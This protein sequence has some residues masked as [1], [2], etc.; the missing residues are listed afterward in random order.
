MDRRPRRIRVR[1]GVPADA[2]SERIGLHSADAAAQ[3]RLPVAQRLDAGQGGRSAASA[4]LR[5]DPRRRAHARLEH[6]RCPRRRSAGAEGYRG[7]LA[8]LPARRAGLPGAP[9]ADGRSAAECDARRP[10]EPH[11][12]QLRR[13]RSDRRAPMGPAEHRAFGGDRGRVTI[14]GESAGSWS[15]NTLLATP[16]STGLFHRA[17]GESG[18][19]FGRGAYLKM[20][21]GRRRLGRDDRRELR[22]GRRGGVDRRAA[23]GPGSR[24][25]SPCPG[26]RTQETIDGLLLPYEIRDVFRQKLQQK[27]PVL[28]GSNADEMTTLGGGREPARRRWRS[29]GSV[30]RRSTETW[31]RTSSR[32]T[33]SR[34]RPTSR[35]RSSRPGATRT[36]SWH[37]RTWA[38]HTVTAGQRAYLYLFSHVPPSPRASELAR[39]SRGGD[40]V[41]VQRA[42]RSASARGGLRLHR[43]RSPARR[44]DVELLGQLR[45]PRRPE[46]ARA[47]EVAR[48]RPEDASRTS[49][50]AIRFARAR[51]S[52]RRSST[53]RRRSRT[54]RGKQ[55]VTE[56]TE[57]TDFT[58]RNGDTRRLMVG[59]EGPRDFAA[60]CEVVPP[61]APLSV[62]ETRHATDVGALTLSLCCAAAAGTGGTARRSNRRQLA[63]H[64]QAGHRRRERLHHHAGEEGRHLLAARRPALVASA[65]CRSRRV[66]VAGNRVTFEAAADS[67]LGDVVR[68]GRPA[69]RGQPRDRSRLA[70][71]WPA[72][73][74]TSRSRC[75]GAAGRRSCS[76]RSSRAWRTSSGSGRSSTWAASFRR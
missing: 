38:R 75:S 29:S 22:E 47:A 17:I 35:A 48:I 46:R 74:S 9:R 76:R 40:S 13:P 71:G 14:G 39:I 28:V 15:V 70:G 43:R 67:K 6:E 16:L 18:G 55:R 32:R 8:Q 72:G 54:S 31:P 45:H 41:R 50:L 1:P 2:V 36:F 27:V 66:T 20:D 69:R 12:G 4:G 44:S 11:L 37:M 26:F 68:Q 73:R 58:R 24:S 21:R 3:R 23:A 10:V 5:L 63:R 25:S 60:P 64:H 51:S 33:A 42:R 30:S 7:R 52:S 56:A 49:S 61:P 34:A 57:E 59:P 19:R 65:R 62:R 53:F